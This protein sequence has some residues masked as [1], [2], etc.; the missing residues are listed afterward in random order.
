MVNPKITYLFGAGASANRVP[1]V[2][3]L[4]NDIKNM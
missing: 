1:V 2:N 3:N 4:Y